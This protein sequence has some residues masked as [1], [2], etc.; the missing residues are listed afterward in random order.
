MRGEAVGAHEVTAPPHEEVGDLDDVTLHPA[1]DRG[2]LADG[3]PT[4]A[5]HVQL[6]DVTPLGTRSSTDAPTTSEGPLFETTM[7]YVVGMPAVAVVVE[8][9]LVIDRSARRT[10]VVVSVAVLLPG[11]GSTEPVEVDTVAVLDSG[12]GVADAL[13]VPVT[14]NVTWPTAA[15]STSSL[16]LPEPDA[17]VHEE[18]TVAEHVQVAPS[19]TPGRA[20]ATRAPAIGD[21]PALVA[22]IV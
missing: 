12:A 16:M 7:L 19:S 9:V 3:A 17:F 21:G 22:T 10:M 13:T 15:M 2:D 5:L 1:G 11:V 6:I 20:S 14:E 8:S 4:V 18:P